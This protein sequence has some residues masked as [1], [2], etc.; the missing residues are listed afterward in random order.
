MRKTHDQSFPVDEEFCVD[1]VGVTRGDAVPHVREA[2]RELLAAKL[3]SN[4]KRA[5]E[6]AHGAIV[7]EYRAGGHTIS[8]F[9]FEF[10]TVESA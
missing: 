8:F 4:F 5:N 1:G 6:L 9:E 10:S 2:A 3:R 7:G